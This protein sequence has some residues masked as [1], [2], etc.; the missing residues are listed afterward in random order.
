MAHQS[1]ILVI[2]VLLHLEQIHHQFYR[3]VSLIQR[4][5][6]AMLFSERV[7]LLWDIQRDRLFYALV[8]TVA[9]DWVLCCRSPVL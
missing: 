7:V 1:A 8:G 5:G 4:E 3:R 6:I 2:T 9:Q